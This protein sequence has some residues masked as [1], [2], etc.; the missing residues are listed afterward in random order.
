MT[1]KE[2]LKRAGAR[3]LDREVAG[4]RLQV[5]NETARVYERIRRGDVVIAAPLEKYRG[6]NLRVCR[7][8]GIDPAAL[9]RVIDSV[10]A[11]LGKE[12]DDRNL[13]DLA[14]MLL[15]PIKFGPLRARTIET[16]LEHCTDLQVICSGVIAKAFHRVDYP[17]LP[18]IEVDDSRDGQRL[19]D[20]HRLPLAMQHYSQVLPRDFERSPNFEIIAFNTI[21]IEEGRFDYTHPTWSQSGTARPQGR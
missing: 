7:P 21:E 20:P 8:R 16:C 13:F 6:H 17:I 10:V 1:L 11:D 4:Y 9:D 18:R 5:P 2:R 14:R 3:F 19:D 15:S 12:Y